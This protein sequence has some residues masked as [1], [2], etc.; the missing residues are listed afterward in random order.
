MT[1]PGSKQTNEQPEE[2]AVEEPV[3]KEQSPLDAPIPDPP[4]SAPDP[5]ADPSAAEQDPPPDAP[6]TEPQADTEA[7][8]APVTAETPNAPTAAPKPAPDAANAAEIP[9]SEA[10]TEASELESAPDA[11]SAKS[12]EADA[13]AEPP[14]ERLGQRIRNRRH[15]QKLSLSELARLSGVSKGYLSQIERSMTAR[16]SADTVFGIS[17][18]LGISIDELYEGQRTTGPGT[19]SDELPPSL[20]EFVEESD[21][22]PADIEMLNAIRFRGAQPED[23]EDWRF[24]YESIRRAVGRSH[25]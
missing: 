24:L 10:E 21:L 12:Q 7:T 1:L 16:P 17:D 23:K 13:E 2:P 4:E 20:L 25:T 5:T 14:S 22:P 19:D 15:A 11:D 6:V 9:D 18:A 3:Q 8:D